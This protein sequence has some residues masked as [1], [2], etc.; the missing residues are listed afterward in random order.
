MAMVMMSRAGIPMALLSDML[1]I[2]LFHKDEETAENGMAAFMQLA[3]PSLGKFVARQCQIHKNSEGEYDDEALLHALKRN[4]NLDIGTLVSAAMELKGKRMKLLMILPEQDRLPHLIQQLSEGQLNLSGLGL[5]AF[6][7]GLETIKG[8]KYLMLSRNELQQLPADLSPFAPIEMLDLA[9]NHL[10]E[11]PES[12][13]A[14][15]ALKGLDLSQNRLHGLPAS[16]GELNSLEALRL[17]RN[18]LQQLPNEI[19]RLEKLELLGCYG[20]KFP[21]LPEIV[22]KMQQLRSLDLGECNLKA[23]PHEL[24]GFAHLES[25]G[26]RDNP[27]EVL[28]GWLGTLPALRFLDLSHLTVRTLPDTFMHHAKVER[29]YL[30]RDTSMDWEQV[31]PILASM[32]RLRYVF[33]RGKRIVRQ[34]QL[35]IEEKVPQARVMWNG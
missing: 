3:I 1:A 11:L 35:L 20:C 13:G 16:I 9:E 33:L 24:E 7:S 34:M 15:K 10:L 17:D 26:L 28:P 32:P 19:S 30:I 8:L 14:L 23:L 27:I 21:V 4:P 2:G 12:I 6:P 18:P 22:W 31:L 25:L 29:I 5:E